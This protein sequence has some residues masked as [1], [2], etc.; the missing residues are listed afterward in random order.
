MDIPITDLEWAVK[1]GFGDVAADDL[2]LLVLRLRSAQLV[3]LVGEE[4]PNPG[5]FLVL[6][7]EREDQQDPASVIAYLE[8]YA[9]LR[10]ESE[11]LEQALLEVPAS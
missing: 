9:G 10:V 5:R 6:L 1:A 8:R 7:P 3:A 4:D 2:A 11:G